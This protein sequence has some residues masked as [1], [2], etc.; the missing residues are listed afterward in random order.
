[1]AF[2]MHREFLEN[3]C[4]PANAAAHKTMGTMCKHRSSR[5]PWNPEAWAAVTR[6]ELVRVRKMGLGA[7]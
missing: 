7:N 4:C 6:F 2:S 1:M 3:P 5:V